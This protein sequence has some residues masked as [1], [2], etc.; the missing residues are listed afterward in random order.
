MSIKHRDRVSDVCAMI[1]MA[2][3]VFIVFRVNWVIG[4]SWQNVTYLAN[5]LASPV[6]SPQSWVLQTMAPFRYRL[7]F[8]SLVQGT[9]SLFFSQTD[10]YGFVMVFR[11]WS[12][13][14]S[15]ALVIAF[16][17]FLQQLNFGRR[18]AFLGVLLLLF[19]PPMFFA[20]IHPVHT[21]EDPIAFLLI[22]LQLSLLLKGRMFAF[23]VVNSIGMFC[24]ETL[25]LVPICYF[26]VSPDRLWLRF[27]HVAVPLITAFLI[28]F[29]LG[30]SSYDPLS[31]SAE[32]VTF[33][34]ETAVGMFLVFGVMWLPGLAGLIKSW[35]SRDELSR[36]LRFLACSGPW[37]L[38]LIVA[39]HLILGRAREIRISFLIFPWIL[40]FGLK[41]FQNNRTV[42][43]QVIK[44]K[45]FW[46]Y[47]LLVLLGSSGLF[48]YLNAHLAE[49]HDL[50]N[51][52]ARGCWL[53]L[54]V[55]QLFLTLVMFYPLFR[56]LTRTD[57]QDFC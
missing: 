42:L 20:Y 29:V 35:S 13:F 7:L 12:V 27:V 21:R 34:Y 4:A 47:V 22:V 40:V 26:I 48:V 50:L 45:L 39:S 55:C 54:I 56:S 23:G 8:F 51:T 36:P 11:F 43:H 18:S 49:Y 16:Y 5:E 33:P 3:L 19:S 30:F 2:G 15:Y 24:R 44:D 46:G 38:G 10:A 17:F 53:K 28:R 31:L 41:W 37:A 9:W 1:I 52:F 57:R 32:N 6:D 14:F 25:L